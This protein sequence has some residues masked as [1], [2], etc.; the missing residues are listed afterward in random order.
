MDD[1]LLAELL[2]DDGAVQAQTQPS[3]GKWRELGDGAT[4]L[5]RRA[6]ARAGGRAQTH[7]QPAGGSPAVLAAGAGAAPPAGAPPRIGYKQFLSALAHVAPARKQEVQV[8]LAQV[9]HQEKQGSTHAQLFHMAQALAAKSFP[10]DCHKAMALLQQVATAKG[11]RAGSASPSPHPAASHSAHSPAAAPAQPADQQ[12][13]QLQ[14]QQQHAAAFNQ[15]LRAPSGGNLAAQAAAQQQAAQQQAQQQAQAQAAQRRPP[16]PPAQ[17]AAQAQQKRPPGEAGRALVYLLSYGPPEER[18]AKKAKPAAGGGGKKKEER[19]DVDAEL[20]ADAFIDMEHETDVLMIDIH[21]RREAKQAAPASTTQ[22]LSEWRVGNEMVRQLAK[23]GLKEMDP[24]CL[25]VVQLAWQAQATQLLQA[26]QRAARHRQDACRRARRAHE[27]VEAKRRAENEALL[28][29]AGSKRAD[30]ETKER[31]QKAKAEMQ[32]R[33]IGEEGGGE[34]RRTRALI[35][36]EKGGTGGAA[37]RRRERGTQGRCSGSGRGGR[38]SDGVALGQGREGR[39]QASAANAAVA[40]TLGGKGAKWDKWGGGGGGGGGGAAEGKT[41]GTKAAS[42]KKGKK[43]AAAEARAKAAAAAARSEQEG[44]TTAT[45]DASGAGAAA[46]VAPAP[47]PA[48]AAAAL[49]LTEADRLQGSRSRAKGG[50]DDAETITTRDVVAAMERDPR[51]CRST[52]LYLLLNG[53]AIQEAA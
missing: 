49:K 16:Q 41:A 50:V 51:Y 29:A 10:Q 48:P 18:E 2:G 14:Q 17:Q 33:G 42:G 5:L 35:A 46:A 12:R 28:K 19:G 9:H 27:R 52:L 7:T 53:C 3:Q 37:L 15:Y 23:H 4:L 34:W 24:K 21:R 36:M 44:R 38:E 26:A 39:Q 31:A 13:Q 25:E 8:L 20:N 22:Y 11:M 32:A 1:P 30:E 40:A 6:G 43:A 47:A 45:F